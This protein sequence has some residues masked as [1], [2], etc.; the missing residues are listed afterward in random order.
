M[1]AIARMP[2]YLG[3]YTNSAESSGAALVIASIGR[4][5]AGSTGMEA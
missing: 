5:D 2:S 1:I 4:T 3:S